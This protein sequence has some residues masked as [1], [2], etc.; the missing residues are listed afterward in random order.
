[1]MV[2]VVWR[3]G[4]R[5]EGQAEKV[6]LFRAGQANIQ[7]MHNGDP[8]HATMFSSFVSIGCPPGGTAI[9]DRMAPFTKFRPDMTPE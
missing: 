8:S 3:T 9:P 5:K 7:H 4:C 2:G 6:V 1:M